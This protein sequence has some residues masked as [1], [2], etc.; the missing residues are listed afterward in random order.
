MTLNGPQPLSIHRGQR[1]FRIPVEGRFYQYVRPSL[2]RA[3]CVRCGSQFDFIATMQSSSIYDPESGGWSMQKG[4]IEGAIEGQGACKKCGAIMAKVDW[5]NHAYFS[6]K[7]PE[8]TVWA[9]NQHHVPALL[10]RIAG[11]RVRLRQLTMHDV[12]LTRFVDRLPKYA[13][14]KKNRSRIERGMKQLLGRG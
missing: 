11:D 1:R 9:W 8:G 4:E 7:V 14:K 5:P 2:I 12:H 6:V 3:V 10:A 13:L